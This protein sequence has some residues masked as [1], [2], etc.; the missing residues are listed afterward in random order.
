MWPVFFILDASGAETFVWPTAAQAQ[1]VL[2]NC[3][4]DIIYNGSLL[5]GIIASTPLVMS[6]GLITVVPASVVA[7]WLVH[8]RVMSGQA[9]G[10]TFAILSGYLAL[11]LQEGTVVGMLRRMV[12]VS[13]AEGTNDRLLPGKFLNDTNNE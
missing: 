11:Q 6:L 2:L 9:I 4:L 1:M 12:G 10:G 7:D 8:G 5:F 3:G 13:A